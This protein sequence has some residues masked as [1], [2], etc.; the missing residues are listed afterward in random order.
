[1]I[2]G[3]SV[4]AEPL[5]KAVQAFLP[6]MQ[7][8]SEKVLETYEVMVQSAEIEEES[9]G[10]TPPEAWCVYV[11]IVWPCCCT[12]IQARQLVSLQEYLI[13]KLIEMDLITRTEANKMIP[14]ISVP[15]TVQGQSLLVSH[16]QE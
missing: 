9:S 16:C 8:Y 3:Q 15:Q 10:F 4:V 2:R 13:G 7:S 14:T 11:L 6:A 5:T 1:M 12:D